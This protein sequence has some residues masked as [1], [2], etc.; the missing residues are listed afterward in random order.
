MS[1][2]DETTQPSTAEIAEGAAPHPSG[3]TDDDRDGD[4]RSLQPLLDDNEAEGF[5]GRW[6][7]IQSEFV[8]DPQQSVES[9]DSLVAELMQELARSFSEER[10]SLESQWTRGDEVD[11]EELRVSLRRY[12]SFFERLLST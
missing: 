8:D 10:A 9:A 11:T 7:A 12:R 6:H 3:T 1:M 4:E 2:S 5:R